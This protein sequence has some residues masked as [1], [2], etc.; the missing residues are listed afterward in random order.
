MKNT[1]LTPKKIAGRICWLVV[2]VITVICLVSQQITINK[3]AER[4]AKLESER[5]NLKEYNDELST[6]TEL[7]DEDYERAARE[8]GYVR[9]NEVIIK[10]AE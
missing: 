7:T 9:P 1:T 3:Y 6:M 5:D 8:Q 4:V 2:I 10:E